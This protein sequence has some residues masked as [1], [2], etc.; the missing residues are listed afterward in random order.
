MKAEGPEEEEGR[1][2]Q[3]K[4]GIQEI[5][6]RKQ[7]KASKGKNQQHTDWCS[8]VPQKLKK[9]DGKKLSSTVSHSFHRFLLRGQTKAPPPFAN[10]LF[11]S[12]RFGL[13]GEG[14]FFQSPFLLFSLSLLGGA[15]MGR[16]NGRSPFLFFSLPVEESALSFPSSS[17]SVERSSDRLWKREEEGDRFLRRRLLSNG[18]MGLDGFGR[19]RTQPIPDGRER[20][21]RGS[22]YPIEPIA[23]QCFDSGSGGGGGRSGGEGV[24]TFLLFFC[25]ILGFLCM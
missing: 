19:R 2:A 4:F 7:K 5:V 20:R 1:G 22:R 14:D 25:R 24:F 18:P 9:Y 6:I 21:G 13:N 12:F 11:P 17:S 16:T 10:I 15:S 3:E 8:S 23:N